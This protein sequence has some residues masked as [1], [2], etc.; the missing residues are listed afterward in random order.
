VASQIRR[1]IERDSRGPYAGHGAEAAPPPVA[2]NDTRL[3]TKYAGQAGA[4]AG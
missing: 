2:A 3:V 4:A 1:A